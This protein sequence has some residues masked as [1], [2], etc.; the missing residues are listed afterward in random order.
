MIGVFESG[1]GWVR[2]SPSQVLNL[3]LLLWVADRY[4]YFLRW[5]A[6]SSASSGAVHVS[7]GGF[8]FWRIFVSDNPFWR[9]VW[10]S[11]MSLAADHLTGFV[12]GGCC[13]GGVVRWL[14]FGNGHV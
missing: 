5:F 8:D 13:V 7:K 6:R 10:P 14:G 2:L 4:G 11:L 1:V 9:L 3:P 12:R